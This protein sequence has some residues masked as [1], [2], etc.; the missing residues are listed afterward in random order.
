M[1]GFPLVGLR[2]KTS[3]GSLLASG[4][5]DALSGR[6]FSVDQ[7]VEEIVRRAADVRRDELYTL[8]VK[9]L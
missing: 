2:S 6:L 3:L 4:R 5:A 7:D 8:R 1:L 9:K